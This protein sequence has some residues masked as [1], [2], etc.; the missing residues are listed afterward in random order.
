MMLV[1]EKS[2]TQNVYREMD[3]D[4]L[5]FFAFLFV[6]IGVMEHAQVLAMIG[7]LVTGLM[8]LGDTAGPVAMLWSGAA[9]SSVTDNIPLAAMLAKTMQPIAEANPDFNSGYWWSVIYGANLGGNIT[10]IGSASTVV[11]VTIMLKQR[12]E[13]GFMD[14]VK[15]ALPFALIQLLLASVYVWLLGIW[16]N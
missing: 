12:L 10:P 6:V 9:A 5:F 15:K 8:G 4:L 16:L 7:G 2:R 14:F 1:R 11:A 3:W 13:I